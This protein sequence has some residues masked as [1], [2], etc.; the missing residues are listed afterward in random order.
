ML[1]A[2]AAGR[3]GSTP[4]TPSIH[5]LGPGLPGYLIPFAPLAFVL[6]CQLQSRT[7]PSPPVFLQ[8]ST[9]F[10]ATP[11]IPRS[12]PA[13]E[14]ASLTPSSPLNL[15]DFTFDLHPHLRPFYPR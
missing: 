9:H 8:I 13:L 12:S 11:G 2:S 3:Q 10:T 1:T 4:A 7:P 5:R 14:P 15:R 6:Q